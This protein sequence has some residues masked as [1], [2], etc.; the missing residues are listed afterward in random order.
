[1]ISIQQKGEV[2]LAYMS[3]LCGIPVREITDE[4]EFTHLYFD[5]RTKTYI[6]ADEYLS[7]NIR[8]K[9]DDIDELT[10]QIRGERDSYLAQT[11]YPE[12]HAELVEGFPKT[13][14]EPQ[15]EMEEGLRELLQQF[16]Q[17]GRSRLHS[18][19]RAYVESIDQ[20]K[21]PE[22]RTSVSRYMLYA[23]HKADGN[24]GRYSDW[25]PDSL[26]TDCALGFQLLRRDPN[27]FRSE[28]TG[29]LVI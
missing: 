7:G 29:D 21:Y 12:Q 9:I 27:F 6:Q 26:A 23:M 1:M 24:Y 18:D 2:D 22:W 14:P 16:S 17:L 5:D 20:T 10:A 4:L 19:F 25:I 8:T 15:N 11:Y 3:E 28:V 13:L